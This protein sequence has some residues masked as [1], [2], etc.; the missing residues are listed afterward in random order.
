MKV[1]I[2]SRGQAA[3]HVVLLAGLFFATLF[4]PS[5]ASAVLGG[6][7]SSVEADRQ[8]MKANVAVTTTGRYEVHEL[9]VAGGNLV[10]EFVS[11]DGNVFGIAWKGTVM[12]QY[13]QLLGSYTKE[14]AKAAASRRNHRAPLAIHEPGF[15]FSAYG[16]M[17]FYAGRAYI[18]SLLPAG[19][20]PQ[21]IQ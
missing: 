7:V 5:R 15:E 10:R 4:L 9:Q 18:P 14:L 16:H 2:R 13:S 17:R 11:P 21:E 8:Q 19:V 6:N 12:P 3:M 1:D 20:L